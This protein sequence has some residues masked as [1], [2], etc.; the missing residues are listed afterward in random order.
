[1]KKELALKD[2]IIHGLKSKLGL[3]D[4]P[5]TAERNETGTIPPVKQD[6]ANVIPVPNRPD[7]PDHLSELEKPKE[8]AYEKIQ[9]PPPVEESAKNL[10]GGANVIRSPKDRWGMEQ[11]Q[12]EEEEDN[13]EKGPLLDA[14]ESEK[15]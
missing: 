2:D 10:D 8:E 11:V 5:V 6:S 13:N 3:P 14:A 12:Q 1:M 15:F 9:T 7:E 4:S